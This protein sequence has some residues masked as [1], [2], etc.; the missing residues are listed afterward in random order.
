MQRLMELASRELDVYFDIPAHHDGE[1]DHHDINTLEQYLQQ[2]FRPRACFVGAGEGRCENHKEL[3]DRRTQCIELLIRAASQPRNSI[4][5]DLAAFNERKPS[6]QGD[7]SVVSSRGDNDNGAHTVRSSPEATSATRS[8]LMYDIDQSLRELI[9]SVQAS[10]E[11]GQIYVLFR[12]DETLQRSLEMFPL[13]RGRLKL[14]HAVKDIKGCSLTDEDHLDEAAQRACLRNLLH[15]KVIYPTRQV[16]DLMIVRAEC[17]K[18]ELQR[19]RARL[20]P[21]EKLIQDGRLYPPFGVVPRHGQFPAHSTGTGEGFAW[22]HISEYSEC[23]RTSARSAWEIL[24]PELGIPGHMDASDMDVHS[25]GEQA[26]VD[27]AEH[28]NRRW[29][30]TASKKPAVGRR[31]RT[32]SDHD[33][34]I[35]SVMRV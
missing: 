9:M 31:S 7:D 11:D 4:G 20:S 12:D 32:M 15:L 35:T 26:W 8:G 2:Y 6:A 33:P 27:S 21:H 14:C 29:S 17:T 34:V 23:A 18:G 10:E 5:T 1:Q 19:A 22:P 3:K 16:G 30:F 13:L 25:P 24:G 28:Q